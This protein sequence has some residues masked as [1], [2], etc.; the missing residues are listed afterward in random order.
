VSEPIVSGAVTGTP[1]VG[2]IGR[3]FDSCTGSPRDALPDDYSQTV[4]GK[5]RKITPG[6]T[7]TVRDASGKIVGLGK[8]GTAPTRIRYD[9]HT[10]KLVPAARGR[11]PGRV[12]RAH[13][14]RVAVQSGEG[15]GRL[16]VL[17]GEGGEP[18]RRDDPCEGVGDDLDVARVVGEKLADLSRRT[19]L[20]RVGGCEV[21]HCSTTLPV[22]S[23]EAA[24][25]E[26]DQLVWTG[27]VPAPIDS[28]EKAVNMGAWW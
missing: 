2:S 20:R 13:L 16:E 1:A 26:R 9:D 5:F 24:K 15:L 11:A 22:G 23:S 6:A 14:L 21:G 12:D 27:C 17:H 7:V 28:S 10:V 3:G 19:A 25:V 8:L 18:R 4:P